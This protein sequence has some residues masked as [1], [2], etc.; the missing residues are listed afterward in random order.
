MAGCKLTKAIAALICLSCFATA[1]IAASYSTPSTGVTKRR[2][3]QVIQDGIYV[4]GVAGLGLTPDIHVTDSSGAIHR[5]DYNEGWIGGAALGYRKGPIR[6]E[7]EFL[8]TRSSIGIYKIDSVIIGET[9]G[10]QRFIGGMLN[11]YYE[12]K[13]LHDILAPYVGLGVGYGDVR[14]DI[15]TPTT[16]DIIKGSDGTFAYQGIVGIAANF[17]R[18]YSVFFDYRYIGTTS[19]SFNLVDSVTGLT[20]RTSERY[21]NHTLNIGINANIFS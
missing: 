18:K 6:V 5:G 19:A 11:G 13:K 2:D 14:N 20:S 16:T 8:Y 10:R 9:T 3:H 12:F 4:G 7:G 15:D 1:S 21:R 17:A